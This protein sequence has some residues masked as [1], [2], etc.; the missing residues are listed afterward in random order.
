MRNKGRPTDC[1]DAGDT[2]DTQT[3]GREPQAHGS[4]AFPDRL[5]SQPGGRDPVR[6]ALFGSIGLISFQTGAVGA[7]TVQALTRES[8]AEFSPLLA[9]GWYVGQ[10][11][12]DCCA[13]A[14]AAAAG[15]R[16]NRAS[17]ASRPIAWPKVLKSRGIHNAEISEIQRRHHRD[18]GRLRRTGPGRQAVIAGRAR[19][20]SVSFSM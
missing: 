9:R 18:Q 13:P 3:G 14:S 7:P 8:L 12:I 11:S 2:G 1:P 20:H 4:P 17:A 10:A 15:R 5:G 19:D 6:V 16:S